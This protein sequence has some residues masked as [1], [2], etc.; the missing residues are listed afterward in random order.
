L[1]KFATIYHN[2]YSYWVEK[3]KFM[4][5][6]NKRLLVLTIA[7]AFSIPASFSQITTN[8]GLTPTQLV[9]NVLLGGGITASNITY[10]GYANSISEFTV[11]A[12]T[13]TFGM[14]GGVYLTTGSYLANDPLGF[15]GGQDGPMGPATNFQ[16]VSTGGF[17]T[18][19]DPDLDILVQNLTGDP[20][21]STNDAAVLEFDFVPQSDTVK[22]RYR[23]ASEEYND[24][25][26]VGGSGGIADVFAFYLTGVSTPLAQ[27]NI[28]LLPGSSTPVSIYTVN[29]GSSFYPTPST[30]PCSNC[31]FYVDNTGGGVNVVYDGLTTVLTA[32]YPVI[33]GETY[34][35]KIAIADASDN[36]YDSG[37][38][39]E[40]GSF[41]SAG[42]VNISSDVNWSTNDTILYEGCSGADITFVRF[43]NISLTDTM[44]YALTGT[45]TTGTDYTGLNGQLIFGPNQ[46]SIIIPVNAIADAIA[47]GLE[48]ITITVNN[49]TNCG[50]IQSSSYTFYINEPPPVTV[51]AGPDQILDCTTL[52]SGAL[53][54]AV[55][56]G[57]IAPLVY[58]WQG[59]PATA[60]YTVSTAGY[61]YVTATDFCGQTAT[62]SVNI[63]VIGTNPISVIASNDTTV[64]QGSLVNLTSQ[65]IGGNG[66]VTYSWSNGSLQQNFS[67]IPANTITYT[68]TVNDQCGET[69]SES[70]TI[71]VDPVSAAYIHG[72]TAVDGEVLFTNTSIPPG[73]TY[74]W[75]FGDGTTST[76]TDPQHQYT[77]AGTYQVMLIVTNPN[78]CVDTTIHDIVIHADSYIYVPNAF[79]PG[80]ADGLND[81]FQVYGLGFSNASIRIYN[82]WGQEIHVDAEGVLTWNGTRTDKSLCPQGV[83]SYRLDYTDGQAKDHTVYG[84]INLIR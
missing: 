61:H 32:V 11:G 7:V 23:F 6:T 43:G 21:M 35:I 30:G 76:D 62:D 18:S 39:L 5:L 20:F 69:A 44:T 81:V 50:A 33:C 46:D 55:G 2:I 71:T 25:V 27:T 49:V 65:F 84:H 24:F 1:V 77:I 40:A 9:N 51:D 52:Q 78:G 75:D 63:T 3:E 12:P 53:L 83:Y 8:G 70:V 72:F 47:E 13:T 73:A 41:A 4:R 79:T 45:A 60:N 14:A 56:N 68:V 19:G 64:C 34:H 67:V 66:G 54:T 26:P 74:V 42:G 38:F 57:G 82:R 31:A 36:A 28:A 15:G 29:N 48:S 59:G 58:H 37:V 17:G 80:N 10:T 16:S 22:F